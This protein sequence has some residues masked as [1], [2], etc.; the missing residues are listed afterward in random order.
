M[1]KV[2]VT[3]IITG[4]QFQVNEIEDPTEWIASCVLTKAWGLGERKLRKQEE[5]QEDYEVSLVVSEVE[6]E[7]EPAREV[8]VYEKDAEGELITEEVTAQDPEG[9]EIVIEQL[10]PTG[11]TEMIPPVMVT[12]VNLRPEYDIV[13]EDITAEHALNERLNSTIATGKKI[14]AVCQ[15]V[16][17]LITGT[18]VTTGKTKEEIDQMETDL[19]AIATKLERNRFDTAKTMITELEN[20]A[21]D[22]L[23]LDVLKIYERHGF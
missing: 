4:Q 1:K 5:G 13:I 17:D 2:I 10:I 20:S 22:S 14:K 23:K 3:N 18:N 7:I 8:P 21:Y 11:E 15:D 6:E 16:L 19:D 9:N 12:F